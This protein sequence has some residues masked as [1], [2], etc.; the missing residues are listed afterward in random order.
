[1]AEESTEDLPSVEELMQRIAEN[2]EALPRQLKNVATYIEQHRSSVMVDRTSDIAASCG[3]HPSAVVRFAQ[4]FGFSGFSDLQA[5]FR[6]AYTGQGTSSPSYQQ[7]IRKL[8]DEKP[9]A[10]SGGSVA[11]EFIAASRGGLEELEAGL[12]DKQF[13]A[14]V[15]ML[16][17]ADNIYVIGVRRSFPVASYIVYALQHTPKRVH[18]VSGF[19]RHVPRTD[20][21]REE[22]RRGDRDQ[23]RAVWQGN[24][25]L[26]A[27]RASPSGEDAGYYG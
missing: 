7:R 22:G 6:Q 3:V 8:I 10:L 26:P 9:G 24:A 2:Y 11:R 19:R 5:V 12:D 17:Q 18:L 15:K 14:A 1:M 4:R 20:S 16:Q 13:D 21:Q 23:L 27:R 25:V